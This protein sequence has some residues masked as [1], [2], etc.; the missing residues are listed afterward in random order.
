MSKRVETKQ[1]ILAAAWRLFA[2][3]G[4]ENTTTRQIAREAGVADGTVFSHFE[5][6]LAILRDGMLNRLEQISE[7][8]LS[9]ETGKS[10]EELGMALIDKYYRYYFDNVGLSRALLK[11]VIWDLDYYELFDQTLFKNTNSAS[12]LTGKMPVIMDA[13]FMT[14]IR[15]LSQP[16]PNVDAALSELHMKIRTILE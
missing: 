13:Y 5:T 12:S 2:E 16:E 1:K 8:V 3:N 6:K 9:A 10:A 15:H 4:Y 7:Q 11:E 14:L